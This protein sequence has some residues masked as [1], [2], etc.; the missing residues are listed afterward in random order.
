LVKDPSPQLADL[1]ANALEAIGAYLDDFSATPFLAEALGQIGADDMAGSLTLLYRIARNW[2]ERL[3][4]AAGLCQATLE[5]IWRL[6]HS[7]FDHL[8]YSG[9]L[10]YGNALREEAIIFREKKGL[11]IEAAVREALRDQGIRAN[12]KGFLSSLRCIIAR[13]DCPLPP[14]L[15]AWLSQVLYQEPLY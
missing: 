2:N 14:P 12:R 7:G 3:P 15:K 13:K 11:F 9:R 10:D 1:G 5:S 6:A 8:T 4:G